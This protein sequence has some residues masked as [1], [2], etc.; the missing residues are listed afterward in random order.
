MERLLD[1][2]LSIAKAPEWLWRCVFVVK[3]T[4]LVYT[5]T[6]NRESLAWER[7]TKLLP[8][9]ETWTPAAQWRR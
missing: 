3:L 8:E 5:L 4:Q 7:R 9:M 2:V 6:A 1:L